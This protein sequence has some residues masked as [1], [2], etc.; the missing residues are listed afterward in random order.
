MLGAQQV[1]QHLIMG[2]MGTT[3]TTTLW[4]SATSSDLISASVKGTLLIVVLEWS[5]IILVSIYIKRQHNNSPE[6]QLYIV[7]SHF[8]SV[9]NSTTHNKLK[10]QYILSLSANIQLRWLVHSLHSRTMYPSLFM[11]KMFLHQ[12]QPLAARHASSQDALRAFCLFCR[13]FKEGKQ[14]NSSNGIWKDLLTNH[15]F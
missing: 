11:S 2:K 12:V 6:F 15:Y 14:S 8:Y 10:E 13:E 1:I 4:K 7:I 5:L 3:T 9:L